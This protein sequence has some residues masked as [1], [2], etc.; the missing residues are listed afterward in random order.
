MCKHTF[1]GSMQQISLSEGFQEIITLLQG[2]KEKMMVPLPLQWR[3]NNVCNG[4]FPGGPVVKTLHTHCQG[5]GFN[6]WSGN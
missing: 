4:K 2:K 5:P 3:L 6:P 1:H